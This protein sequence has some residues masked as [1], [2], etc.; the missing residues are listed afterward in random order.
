LEKKRQQSRHARPH[1]QFFWRAQTH[2]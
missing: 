1:R 2:R